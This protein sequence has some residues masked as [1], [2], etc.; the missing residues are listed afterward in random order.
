MESPAGVTDHSKR[1]PAPVHPNVGVV[2]LVAGPGPSRPPG[3]G[4]AL[5]STV[6]VYVGES[7]AFCAVLPLVYA[8]SNV[9]TNHAKVPAGTVAV[10]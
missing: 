1:G 3:A 8:L 10:S 2:S 7:A 5:G 6:S 9:R 4:G